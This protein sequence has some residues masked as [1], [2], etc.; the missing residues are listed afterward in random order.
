MTRTFN[1]LILERRK[2]LNFSQKDIA[3]FV[4]VTEATI[5]RWESG[6]IRS[7]GSAYIS[8]LLHVLKMPS[9][10]MSNIDIMTEDINES[11]APIKRRRIP[12]LGNVAAGQ[13]IW[14]EENYGEYI[15]LDD[16]MDCD[17]ALRV[18][19]DSMAPHILDGDTVF[20]KEQPD[21]N[22]GEIAV[23]MYENS[24]TLKRVYKIK[25]G[26][27]LISINSAYEPMLFQGAEAGN[28]RILGKAVKFTREL[29]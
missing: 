14:A 3:D 26:L 11:I 7:I 5:S 19:G 9:D 13:P 24:A 15:T 16:Q 25:G 6:K 1:D 22:N 21:V 12:M 20:V 17:F 29:K 8:R 28:V 10:V 2:E 27:Q 23:V 4:G 18:K